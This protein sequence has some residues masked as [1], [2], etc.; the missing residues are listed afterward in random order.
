MSYGSQ[1]GGLNATL[2]SLSS[3]AASSEEERRNNLIA[4]TRD[5][6]L[7]A[8]EKARDI[9]SISGEALAGGLG[10]SNFYKTGKKI[11][12][13]VRK[14][15]DTAEN[16]RS[17]FQSPEE[18]TEE[19]VPEGPSSTS[20]T[21]FLSAEPRRVGNGYEP[22]EDDF[23]ESVMGKDTS[24]NALAD[25]GF[26]EEDAEGMFSS[27][28]RIGGGAGEA[29]DGLTSRLAGGVSEASDALVSTVGDAAASAGGEALAAIAGSQ[30]LDAIPVIGEVTAAVGAI[31]GIGEGIASLVHHS[32]SP[33]PP[34][35]SNPSS[36]LVGS[37]VQSRY[38]NL[39]PSHDT[40]VDR[41]GGSGVF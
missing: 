24:G 2:Q 9:E 28:S 38:A 33:A 20:E 5:K 39:I 25:A 17:Q 40:S 13:A 22:E 11:V 36:F 41:G 6:A 7:A 23:T 31:A 30:V 14:V 27:S 37:D 19:S 3:K 4:A 29:L 26:T 8:T 12:A 35:P 21:S 15:R 16:I 1:I 10:V 32:S 34:P 18:T